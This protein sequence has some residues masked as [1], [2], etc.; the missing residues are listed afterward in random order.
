MPKKAKTSASTAFLEG[1][2]KAVGYA[3]FEKVILPVVPILIT[4]LIGW[5]S[6]VE[7]FYFWLG[8]L[9][10]LAFVFMA[11]NSFYAWLYK[12]TVKNKIAL[13]DIQV[14]NEINGGY[15]VQ[16]Q[17]KSIAEYPIDFRINQFDVQFADKVPTKKDKVRLQYLLMV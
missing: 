11:L 8:F 2:I 5:L 10:S 6:N 7:I 1:G 9:A 15:G 16:L 12:I 17:L 4:I 3:V 13:A 14:F